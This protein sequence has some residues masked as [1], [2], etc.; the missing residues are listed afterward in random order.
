[1]CDHKK[2]H[3]TST[4]IMLKQLFEMKETFSNLLLK[5]LSKF[6]VLVQN[7]YYLLSL[8]IESELLNIV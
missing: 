2:T 7:F 8:Y 4:K 1:M 6:N 3:R 5:L